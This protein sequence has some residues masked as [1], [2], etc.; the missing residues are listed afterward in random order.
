MR[1]EPRYQVYVLVFCFRLSSTLVRQGY[2][3]VDRSGDFVYQLADLFSLYSVRPARRTPRARACLDSSQR[4]PGLY[5][6]VS[7]TAKLG[8]IFLDTP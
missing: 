3:P 6:L 7:P 4:S 5:T 2:L 8:R 1:A